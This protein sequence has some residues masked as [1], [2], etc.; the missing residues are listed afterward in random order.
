MLNIVSQS[1]TSSQVTGPQK[2]VSNLIKGLDKIGYPYVINQR[3]DS[4]ARLWIHDDINALKKLNKL[5]E[6]IK[7]VV[8]PNLYIFPRNI[9][10]KIVLSREVYI[11]PSR[12]TVE[13]WKYFGYTKTRLDSWP[14]GID[15][16][17]FYFPEK[18][19]RTQVLIYF[20]D[21]FSEELSFC[22]DI[23]NEKNISYSIIKYGEYTEDQF[24]GELKKSHYVIWIGRQ[25]SQGIALQEA[26]STDTPVLVWDVK[27]FGHSQWSQENN[28]YLEIEKEYENC[29]S[30]PFFDDS[31]GMVI[32][33]KNQLKDAIFK[34]NNSYQDF[35]PRKFV[36]E[37][38][39]LEKQALDFLDLYQKHFHLSLE[40]GFSEKQLR[41]GKW[42]NAKLWYRIWMY[43]KEM[44]K[45]IFQ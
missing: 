2:V 36:Q 45:K 8:G 37:N 43:I 1:I 17:E 24:K 14:V 18:R 13:A 41:N 42:R 6:N 31:C 4:C 10:K 11:H 19:N 39:S 9:S 25:E 23:L 22:E 40:S 5:P 38:L 30:A 44:I 29:T 26:L 21:R 34:M 15:T 27:N 3:L 16:E 20:K 32:D 35:A 33:N 12:W 7:V 28:F